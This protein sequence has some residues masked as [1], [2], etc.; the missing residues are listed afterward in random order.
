MNDAELIKKLGGTF[1]VAKMFSIR[2]PSVSEWKRKGIPKAR[3]MYLEVVRPDLFK[4]NT[5]TARNTNKQ[6]LTAA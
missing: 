1:V 4:K 6:Y 3:R 2:P 5:Q